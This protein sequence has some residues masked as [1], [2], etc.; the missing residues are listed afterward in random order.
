MDFLRGT[1]PEWLQ[2]A[3]VI[4]AGVYHRIYTEL[5][6][7]LLILWLIYVTEQIINEE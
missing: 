6:A 2:R 3:I 5:P 4:I 7:L 1:Q